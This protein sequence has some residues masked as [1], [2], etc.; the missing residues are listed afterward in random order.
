MR[1]AAALVTGVLAVG[2]L[3]LAG[4]AGPA[5]AGPADP[6]VRSWGLNA[7]GQLGTGD[8]VDR[9]TPSAVRG[10]RRADVREL[11]AGGGSS[12]RNHAIALLE[13]GTV[14]SWGGNNKGQLG[15]GSTVDRAVPGA[16]AG[17]TGVSQ[18]AAGIDF[19]L[20]VR[21]GRVLSWGSNAYGQLGDGTATD[22]ATRPVRTQSLD[23]VAEVSA[24]CQF[25][26]AL[27]QDGTVWTWGRN[28]Q[29]QL[30]DGTTTDRNTPG[31]CPA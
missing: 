19:A 6:W 17:L 5:H 24:G 28:H 21:D 26:V 27:R 20:A 22:P 16:V 30:G 9:P 2:V 12:D 23:R 18:V 10:L 8:T 4:P 1:G 13:D 25:A 14:Q 3:T 15:D 11:A 29:G 31:G 7:A